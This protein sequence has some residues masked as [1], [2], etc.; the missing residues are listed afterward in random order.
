MIDRCILN[1]VTVCKAGIRDY[2]YVIIVV[3]AVE[4]EHYKET[5]FDDLFDKIN[6]NQFTRCKISICKEW[7]NL[8]E[9]TNSL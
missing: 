2:L 8:R 1:R 6:Y 9:I 3:A 4:C 5:F 7:N